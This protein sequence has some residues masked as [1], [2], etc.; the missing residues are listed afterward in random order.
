MKQAVAVMMGTVWVAGHVFAQGNL[1]PSSAPAET[2]KTL[3]QI[4]PRIDVSTLTNGPFATYVIAERGSYYLTADVQAATNRHGITVMADDVTIDLNGFSLIGAGKAVGSAG[5]GINALGRSNLTVRNGTIQQFREEGVYCN[6]G[7]GLVAEALVVENCGGA[8]IHGY[9][10]VVVRDCLCR[11]N[12]SYG[13]LSNGKLVARNCMVVANESVG[14]GASGEGTLV[15]GCV[16]Q[17]NTS[18]GISVGDGSS[19]SD[20][21][22]YDNDGT[23]ISTGSGASLDGCTV[24]F[25]SSNYGIF[26]SDGSTLRGCT[27]NYNTGP[28]T[29]SYGIYAASCCSI[30]GCSARFNGNNSTNEQ[31]SSSQG[32][33]ICAKDGSTVRDC[34]ARYNEGDGIRVSDKTSVIANTSSNNGNGGSGSGIHATGADNRIDGNNVTANDYGIQVDS[35]GN[36]IVRNSA[37]GN[38]TNWDVASGNACLVVQATT[39]GAISGNAGGSSL[40]STDP[41]AN[42]TF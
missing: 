7:S 22:V 3:Q 11:E 2:M 16:V 38:S 27:A 23:G 39:G 20:C 17:R 14:I 18:T 36:I 15:A 28:G 41:N 12:G 5:H 26:V 6:N 1:V 33:G 31:G 4:E 24:Y 42:F 34:S 37:S 30:I 32:V 10:D 9:D 40:G 25:S 35:A 13:I 8:G 19:V 21:V 29:S